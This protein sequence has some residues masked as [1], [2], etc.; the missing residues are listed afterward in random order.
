M[1]RLGTWC[2]VGASRGVRARGIAAMCDPGL[3]GCQVK[4]YGIGARKIRDNCSSNR[5]HDKCCEWV[6]GNEAGRASAR[7]RHERAR[8]PRSAGPALASARGSEVAANIYDRET[9]RKWGWRAWP[10][11]ASLPQKTPKSALGRRGEGDLARLA[12][13][14]R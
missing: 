8:R 7:A 1:L 9:L 13:G 2:G 12:R 3:R 5:L 11:P 4:H 14:M 10:A 6:D